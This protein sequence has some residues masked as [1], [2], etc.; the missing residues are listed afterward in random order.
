[1]LLYARV[2]ILE[3]KAVRLPRGDVAD[4]IFLDADPVG[5]AVSWVALGADRL[6]IV[7]LD[8]AAFGDHRNSDMIRDLINAS[9]VPVQVGGGARSPHEVER[10][11]E[12]G[13]DT[14]VLGTMP[15]V[16]QVLFWDVCRDH[17]GK[18]VVSLDVR[19]DE[20]IAIQGWTQNSGVYLE[21]ALIEMSSAG[22]A[23]FM[24]TEVGRD[25][26]AE[27]PNFDALTRALSI[28]DE[29][30]V[31]AGG[32]RNMDDLAALKALG[33]NGRSLAGVVVGREITQGR[34]TIEEAAALVQR[35]TSAGP[36]TYE[37][38]QANVVRYR[39]ESGEATDTLGIESFLAWLEKR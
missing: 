36:W 5:R 31:A 11:L 8:A 17:P 32:V 16:D 23:G 30:V 22:A 38:L 1:M 2:N 10:L 27:P 26:L 6:H 18:I 3:G 4:A 21:E 7:D 37:E 12:A 25:A 19:P 39:E 20:E 28:V 13:A 34:F 24:I 9:E 29:P 14:V 15:I 33:S 35:D